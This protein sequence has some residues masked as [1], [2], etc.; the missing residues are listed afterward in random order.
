MGNKS[1][2]NLD[3]YYMHIQ[4]IGDKLERFL[5]L[6]SGKNVPSNAE[7]DPLKRKKIEDFWDFHYESDK[8]M[9]AQII[10]YFDKLEEKKDDDNIDELKEALIVRITNSNDIDLLLTKIDSLRQSQFMPLVLFLTNDDNIEIKIPDKLMNIEP[11][12]IFKQAYTEKK[13][14]FEEDG[15]I[16]NILLRFCSIHNDLGDKFILGNEE[17]NQIAYDLVQ[18]Y[19]PFNLNLCC[20]GRFGQG[21]S[22]GVNF[23]LQEYKAKES[24]KSTSQTKSLTYYQVTNKPIRI[25]DIPGFEDKNT[26]EIAI[27]KFKHCGE[28]INKLKD[29][30]HIILYFFSYKNDRL[31][32][33]IEFPLI[34]EIIK[35]PSIKIIYVI[36]HSNPNIT[37]ILKK[38]FID[39]INKGLNK[40]RKIN[41]FEEIKEKINKQMKASDNNVVFINFKK[42]IKCDFEEFGKEELFKRIYEAFIQTDDYKSSLKELSPK[43]IEKKIDSL[44][45]KA[46][47]V[48]KWHKVGGGLIGIIPGIDWLIQKFVIK[49][50]AAKKIG[51]IF[52]I[53]VKLINEEEK[54]KKQKEE[55]NN[56]SV[57]IPDFCRKNTINRKALDLE[58]NMEQIIEENEDYKIKNSVK[59]VGETGS[60]LGGIASTTMSLSRIGASGTSGASGAA[61]AAGAI[62]AIGAAGA[63]GATGTA[64]A[65]GVILRSIALNL[66]GTSLILVGAVVGISLGLYFTQKHCEEIIDKLA[67]YYKNNA[68]KVLNSYKDAA[69]YFLEN[70]N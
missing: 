51:Q 48:V 8:D 59:I 34:D 42:D 30:I 56:N 21:K 44:K 60:Y 69:I 22:T 15:R 27:K 61:G 12:L 6:I 5:E 11:R 17:K 36:T 35:Y 33:N 65:A 45:L 24:S 53:D 68:Y 67:E 55:S 50:N 31:F 29:N 20:I 39:N 40:K 19:F 49:K 28:E 7:N 4:L 13:E 25:L 2:D 64:G 63:A 66:L 46:E 43:E 70:S 47:D 54:N 57:N 16:K 3:N 41:N 38:D 58:I 52:G 23:I 62:G 32:S 37:D 14:D 26:V 10:D 18:N 9:N 1:I